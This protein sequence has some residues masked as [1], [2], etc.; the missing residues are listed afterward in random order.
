MKYDPLNCPGW[1]LCL[2]TALLSK[3]NQN[4]VLC[5]TLSYLMLSSSLQL[6]CL[7]P[8]LSG[9]PINNNKHGIYIIVHAVTRKESALSI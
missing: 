7:A 9:K 4:W 5:D 2:K 1:Q 8:V 6:V 3:R